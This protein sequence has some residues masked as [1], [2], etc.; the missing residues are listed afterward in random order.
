MPRDPLE[1]L[2]LRACYDAQVRLDEVHAEIL[3]LARY[4]RSG[5]EEIDRRVSLEVAEDHALRELARETRQLLHQ[6]RAELGLPLPV[7]EVAHG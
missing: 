5:P 7:L 1:R 4:S 6:V 3:G 2:A